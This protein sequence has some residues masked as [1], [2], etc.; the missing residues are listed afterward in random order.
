MF[1]QR[2]VIDFFKEHKIKTFLYILLV[3][4]IYPLE[5]IF[6]A[7]LSANLFT[8]I[9]NNNILLTYLIYIVIVWLCIIIGYY[10]KN[11]IESV[12]TPKY[13][14][15]IRQILFTNTI[16]LYENDYEDLKI[17][18]YLPRII[19]TSRLMRDLLFL[20]ID[21]I[22]PE[23]LIIGIITIYFLINFRNIGLIFTTGII[24]ILFIIYV[25]GRR[26]LNTAINKTETYFNKLDKIFDS[27]SNL[28][29]IYINNQNTNEINN[30]AKSENEYANMHTNLY[31]MINNITIFISII[32][33]IVFALSL[34]IMYQ[35]KISKSITN[36]E[37]IT[38]FIILGYYLKSVIK[39]V[40]LFSTYITKLASIKHS[41]K[42]IENI[43]NANNN[44]RENNNSISIGNI[45]FNNISFSYKKEDS[46]EKNNN[47]VYKN[48]NLQINGGEKVAIIGNSGSGKTTLI[49]L[50]LKLHKIETGEIYVDNKNIDYMSNK[51]IRDNI[52]YVN[53]KT[54]LF[55]ETV[56]Y[57]IKYG[58]DNVT[59]EVIN[60]IM[61]SYGI[62][63]LFKNME[64]GLNSICGP[65]GSNLSLGMQKVIIIMRGILKIKGKIYVF[66][67]PL[68]GLDMNT[69]KKIIKLILDKTS[70]K[71]LIIIT[72]DVEII[73]Y[74][75]RTIDLNKERKD[76]K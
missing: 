40:S 65:N 76:S 53:Q 56:M 72:H 13:L 33:I 19:E 7:R 17:G 41:Q 60:N 75:D 43:L 32:I 70:G 42:F 39:L 4:I 28:A 2:L 48:F 51:Y 59:D 20:H 1:F 58:N 8:N 9:N 35:S 71:T 34:Y 23:L 10:F 29:N 46:N 47:Y 38:L 12:L 31:V 63:N 61:S 22:L 57:N 52:I 37:F 50:L 21:N 24:L 68:A 73:P 27:F 11:L 16:Y 5:S 45:Q 18:K 44:N 74:L 3:L 55:N 36:I 49:K 62:D 69:R 26:C 66:D 15:F 14:S 67:E 25:Y 30:N 6:L 54:Q 64:K